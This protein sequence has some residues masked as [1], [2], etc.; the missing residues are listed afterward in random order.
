MPKI[1]LSSDLRSLLN[2][3]RVVLMGCS[4]VRAIYKDLVCLY[5]WDRLISEAT[6]KTKMEERCMGDVLVIHGTKTNGRDYREERVFSKHGTTFSF[7][8]L[9]RIYSE[10]VE[11]I[12]QRMVKDPPDVVIAG[13]CL[14][15]ITRWGPDGVEDYKKNVPRFFSGLQQRL[16]PTTLVMWLTAAPLSQEV[17]GGFL[18]PQLDFLKYSLRFHILEANCF[19]K[20]AADKFGIDVLDLHFHLRFLLEHRA[21]DG[22]HWEPLAVRLCTN[23]VLTHVAISWDRPLPENGYLNEKENEAM[24]AEDHD[25]DS[26]GVEGPP[27]KADDGKESTPPAAISSTE[28]S[29]KS[30]TAATQVT[31]DASTACS[32]HLVPEEK[33][34]KKKKKKQQQ[35]RRRYRKPKFGW[36]KGPW[37][38]YG[39]RGSFWQHDTRLNE[40]LRRKAD[41]GRQGSSRRRK[42]RPSRRTR[43]GTKDDAQ[44]GC[45]R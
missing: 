18:V 11:S 17:R 8:F 4:N 3:K 40:P 16:P 14:W 22:I 31:D 21:R 24:Q 39:K 42:D 13:S 15:D 29:N 1:F 23:L 32:L 41:V 37:Q 35:F 28:T 5:Q 9:T 10:Y 26:S 38:S 7:C 33:K 44:P 43:K 6:L 25:G 19:C 27:A 36:H 45:S 30:E 34:K 2:K 12:L 20:E